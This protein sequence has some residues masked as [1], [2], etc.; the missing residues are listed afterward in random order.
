[1][2][3]LTEGSFQGWRSWTAGRRRDGRR[4]DNRTGVPPV[5]V[6]PAL[7]AIL[8]PLGTATALVAV[9]SVA[10]QS[11]ERRPHRLRIQDDLWCWETTRG[12]STVAN[13]VWRK[14]REEDVR[15]ADLASL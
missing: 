6:R 11:R 3:G 13:P 14:R 1:M 4:P 8:R 9:V 10:P 7:T 5:R 15:R 2:D 12:K